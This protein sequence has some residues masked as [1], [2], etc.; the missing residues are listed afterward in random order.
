MDIV[1]LS[2]LYAMFAQ[3]SLSSSTPEPFAGPLCVM[4][5]FAT[6]RHE[7]RDAYVCCAGCSTAIYVRCIVKCCTV[8]Y[9][10]NIEYFWP[11][12]LLFCHSFFPVVFTITIKRLWYVGFRFF[13][14]DR[15]TL[16]HCQ[17][18]CGFI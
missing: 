12:I 17:C 4:W 11:S 15:M 2:L 14:D 5:L 18:V 6:L 9:M 8:D 3:Y 7:L 10:D 13:L 1:P 16:C